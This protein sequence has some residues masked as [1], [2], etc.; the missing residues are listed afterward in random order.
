MT[1]KDQ[2][3]STETRLSHRSEMITRKRDDYTQD[4][5]LKSDR[6]QQIKTWKQSEY[7]DDCSGR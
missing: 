4:D 5:H 3:N 2:D 7:Q 1:A 6:L